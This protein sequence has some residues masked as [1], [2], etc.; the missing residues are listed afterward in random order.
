[1]VTLLLVDIGMLQKDVRTLI[2]AYDD[3]QGEYIEVKKA[4][5]DMQYK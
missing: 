1:M 2:D 3:L 4:L 5:F